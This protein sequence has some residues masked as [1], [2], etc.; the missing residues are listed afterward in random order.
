M[1]NLLTLAASVALSL[2]VV[3]CSAEQHGMHYDLILDSNTLS[4]DQDEAILTAAAKWEQAIP[5]LTFSSTIAP[6]GGYGNSAHTVC[7]FVDDGVPPPSALA[8]TKYS[9]GMLAASDSISAD[10]A[11]V[12]IWSGFAADSV[13]NSTVM[14]NAMAHELGHC[15][16]HD[17][18]HLPEG[19]LMM[20]S[21]SYHHDLK[22]TSADIDYVMSVR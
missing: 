10:S 3:G 9:H 6:C 5:G 17:G 20:P 4:Y 1:K 7:F 19:N 8:T 15:I 22:I 14:I 21:T 13:G 12:H 2:S 11:T 18:S 16:T